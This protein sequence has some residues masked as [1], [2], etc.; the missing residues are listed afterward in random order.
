M[1][2]DRRARVPRDVYARA[3]VHDVGAFYRTKFLSDEILD[4]R[5]FHPLNRFSIRFAR[6]MWVYDNVREG[7]SLLDLGC[8]AGMLALLKRK[9][10]FLAGMDLSGDCAAAARRNGYDLALQATLDALPFADASFDYVTSLDVLGHVPLEDKD[11]V[12]DEVRRVLKPG[13]VTLHGIEC[14]DA[15]G[16]AYEDM[17]DETLRRFVEVDGH[18]GLEDEASHAKRFARV[19]PHVAWRSRFTLCL[20]SE[21]FLKQA[22]RY[23]ARYEPDW[24]EYL[25]GLSFRER[26]AFDL[27]M[28]YVFAAISDLDLRLPHSG[29]YVLVKASDAPLGP[30]YNEH[31]D[32]RHLL[33]DA[34][35][36]PAIASRCLDR[37]PDVIF[38]DGWHEAN[39]LPPIAR[40]M[41]ECGRIQ[42]SA[43]SVSRIRLDATTHMPDLA[44][45]PLTV[46]V[47]LNGA[48]IDLLS[49]SR[50]GWRH[51]DIVVP[52][53]LR[54]P[55][56]SRFDLQLRADRTWRPRPDAAHRDDRYLSIAVC[57]IEA[58]P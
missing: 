36:A 34:G 8:G 27:A 19:F 24:L 11:R 13:G 26:R 29:F 39:D 40:W 48:P 6:T 17:D 10:V 20:S 1:T 18:V 55:D 41:Q 21:E 30:F 25:R 49:F 14:L 15:D 58:V 53:R 3:G 43:P 16:R 52:E 4:A 45:K 37:S 9:H 56:D 32:R 12:L 23:G 35:A 7:S 2:D 5:Y 46:S 42:F 44:D 28:G 31:R 33:A 51:A 22:D 54:R 50:P 47:L 38:D 57:N